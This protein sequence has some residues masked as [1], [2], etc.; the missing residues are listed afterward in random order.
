MSIFATLKEEGLCYTIGRV[1]R[2]QSCFAVARASTVMWGVETWVGL[3]HIGVINM[4]N[5]AL[6]TLIAEKVHTKVPATTLVECSAARH[7]DTE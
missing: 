6:S 3:E 5:H 1:T 2:S 4:A 7:S